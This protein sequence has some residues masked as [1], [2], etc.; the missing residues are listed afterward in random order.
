MSTNRLSW[1]GVGLVVVVVGV[2]VART[3]RQDQTLRSPATEPRATRAPADDAGAKATER[4]AH[5]TQPGDRRSSVQRAKAALKEKGYYTG[6]LDGNYD[7]EVVDA[8][9]KF[10]QDAGLKPTGNLDPKTYAALGV[11][12]RRQR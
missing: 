9:K 11:E 2:L 5:A 1:V 6:A 10:Q 4:P 12:L 8:V 7:R 3:V